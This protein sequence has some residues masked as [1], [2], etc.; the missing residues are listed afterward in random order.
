MR[1]NAPG[2]ESKFR[3]SRI[4]LACITMANK[5]FMELMTGL[6]RFVGLVVNSWQRFALSRWVR[7]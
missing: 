1:L 4:M 7:Q 5:V 3:L 2:I 6:S